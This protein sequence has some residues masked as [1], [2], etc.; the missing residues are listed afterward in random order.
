M[1]AGGSVGVLIVVTQVTRDR[2]CQHETTL[3]E[4][5]RCREG[6]G[7][8]EGVECRRLPSYTLASIIHEPSENSAGDPRYFFGLFIVR[9]IQ[10]YHN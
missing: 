4:T 3:R 10:T 9:L 5:Y 1:Q 6:E 8:S 7:K 2:C